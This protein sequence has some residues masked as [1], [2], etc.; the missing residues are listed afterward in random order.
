MIAWPRITTLAVRSVFSPRIGRSRALSLPW[1][2]SHR[3][4]WYCS[5]LW[6]ASGISSSM[7]RARVGARS[8][9]TS[10]GSPW[11]VRAVVKNLRAEAISLWRE[12]KTSMTCPCWSIAR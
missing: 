6:N 8:V 12:T 10:T 2:A 5:V 3:L 1:S 11:A 7:T 4:F 9:T